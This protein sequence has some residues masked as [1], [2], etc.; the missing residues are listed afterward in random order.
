M[1]KVTHNPNHACLFL[2]LSASI[3]PP[4][5]SSIVH[6]LLRNL[7]PHLFPSIL[8]H[9]SRPLLV[10]LHLP[11]MQFSECHSNFIPFPLGSLVPCFCPSQ[12]IFWV[13]AVP[14]CTIIMG[15]LYHV[16]T[17]DIVVHLICSMWLGQGFCL[18]LIICLCR[19]KQSL[20]STQKYI[21][22]WLKFFK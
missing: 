18:H 4:S 13:L 1:E 7:Q 9:A 16:I 20:V 14:R 15:S 19:Y 22:P 10:L 8:V 21:E 2:V 12:N 6:C 5:S 17:V 11:R 3:L